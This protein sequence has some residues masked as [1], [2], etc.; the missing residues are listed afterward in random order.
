MMAKSLLVCV[1][2]VDRLHAAVDGFCEELAKTISAK[3]P[4]LSLQENRLILKEDALY[5]TFVQGVE[6]LQHAGLYAQAGET[7]TLQKSYET[8]CGPLSKSIGM[9]RLKRMRA[10]AKLAIGIEWAL[11]KIRSLKPKLP[12]DIEVYA[13]DI[14]TKLAKKG[15]K[16]AELPAYLQGVLMKMS[17]PQVVEPVEPVADEPLAAEPEGEKDLS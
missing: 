11:T 12:G 14:L 13:K 9:S 8:K 4:A 6:A 3:L 10:A 5:M 17:Q 16:V 1:A 2:D 15:L 7:L